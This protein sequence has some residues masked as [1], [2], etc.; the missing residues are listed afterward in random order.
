MSLPKFKTDDQSLSL[1]QTTWASQIDPVLQLPFNSGV[2]LSNVPLTSGKNIIN[3]KLS[4]DLQGYIVIGQTGL[5]NI[6][7]LQ[8]LNPLPDK[9]LW[10]QAS[11]GVTINLLVF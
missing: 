10:L 6:Y 3:H 8:Y 1:L 9:N 2:I 7:S 11:S 4:R 5:S